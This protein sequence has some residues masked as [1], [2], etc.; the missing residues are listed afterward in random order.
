MHPLVKAARHR[1]RVAYLSSEADRVYG[2]F[3]EARYGWNGQELPDP[4]VEAIDY[5]NGIGRMHEITLEW[6]DS[7]M[8]SIG[9]T[10][11]AN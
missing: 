4:L 5:G 1:C 8:A 3:L 6:L 9:L 10:P 2:Q 7:Q 11:K